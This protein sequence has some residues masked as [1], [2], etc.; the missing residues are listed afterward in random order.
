[1]KRIVYFIP[2]VIIGLLLASGSAQPS[3]SSDSATWQA[4]P[5][6][7]TTMAATAVA[8]IAITFKSSDDLMLTA[9]LYPAAKLPAPALL[10]L[11]QSPG[12]KEDWF[13]FAPVWSAHNYNVIALD[14]RGNGESGLKV[15]WN[16]TV[17]DLQLVLAQIAQLP[18]VDGTHIAI[19]GASMGGQ[20]GLVACAKFAN[21]QALVLLSAGKGFATS[22]LPTPMQALGKRPVLIVV[23]KGNEPYYST[24]KDFDAQAVGD[25]QFVVYDTNEHGLAMLYK[26]PELAENIGQWLDAH[27]APLA[28]PTL[29]ATAP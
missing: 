23:A 10:L 29:A 2:V 17:D 25:H 21:C 12:Q 6:A 7:A 16:K 15:D 1:M 13:A 8:P 3:L 4:T 14:M 11:H 26:H 9:L 24:A 20:E 5:P 19:L 27:L 28:A 22:I 18:G